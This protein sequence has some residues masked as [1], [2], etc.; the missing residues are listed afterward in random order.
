MSARLLSE[1]SMCLVNG[2]DRTHGVV[3]THAGERGGEI[4]QQGLIFRIGWRA[5]EDELADTLPAVFDSDSAH[6]PW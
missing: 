3:G 4:R 2:R 1:F 6:G 5:V